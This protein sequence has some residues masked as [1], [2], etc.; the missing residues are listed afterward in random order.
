MDGGGRGRREAGGGGRRA[1]GCGWPGGRW[2]TEPRPS[3]L[4][5]SIGPGGRWRF[6]LPQLH[7]RPSKSS[8]LHLLFLQL[9]PSTPPA[10]PLTPPPPPRVLRPPSPLPPPA[11][12]PLS[13]LAPPP[14]PP[15]FLPLGPLFLPPQ[16]PPPNSTSP[17]PFP[18]PLLRSQNH[19]HTPRPSHKI[20]TGVHAHAPMQPTIRATSCCRPHSGPHSSMQSKATPPGTSEWSFA[21]V[22]RDR[23]APRRP[24]DA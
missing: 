6:A 20:H 9:P 12:Q 5:D 11:T 16:H 13:P 4:V 24:C 3:A 2:R 22:T 19:T 23:G 1:A 7:P 10:L 21:L 8:L 17:P 15:R 18:S 14:L